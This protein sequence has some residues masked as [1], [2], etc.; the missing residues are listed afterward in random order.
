MPEHNKLDYNPN[1]Y[2]VT[3]SSLNMP[4]QLNDTCELSV[5]G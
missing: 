3:I 4:R 5:G 1:L 2:N